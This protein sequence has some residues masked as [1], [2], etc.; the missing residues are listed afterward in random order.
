MRMNIDV[1]FKID[2]Q[3]RFAQINATGRITGIVI[4]KN[5]IMYKI[6]YIFNGKIKEGI[7][8]ADEIRKIRNE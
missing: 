7:F 2:E 3:V 5:G 4:T 8:Y 1:N 6:R